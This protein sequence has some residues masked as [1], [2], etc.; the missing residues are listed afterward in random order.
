MLVCAFVTLSLNLYKRGQVFLEFTVNIR[1]SPG[2]HSRHHHKFLNVHCS[3][4]IE[5]VSSF[6]T[7]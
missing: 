4:L 5:V 2:H 1:L 3:R 7:Q 6:R